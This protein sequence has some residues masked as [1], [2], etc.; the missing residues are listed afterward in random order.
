MMVGTCIVILLKVCTLTISGVIE[1]SIDGLYRGGGLEPIFS[2]AQT[3]ENGDLK[4][5]QRACLLL[6]EMLAIGI[7]LCIS[8]ITT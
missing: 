5:F 2:L 7:I 3:N 4:I 8:V 1:V 6:A